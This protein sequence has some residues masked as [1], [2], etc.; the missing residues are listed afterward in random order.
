MKTPKIQMSE[1]LFVGLMLASVGGF[2]ESYSFI[3]RAGVFANCQTGNMVLLAMY[4]TKG[5]WMRVISYLIPI[6][7]FIIG[8]VLTE[9]V[10]LFAL[11]HK[12]HWRQYIILF[13]LFLLAFVGFIPSG[14]YDIIATTVI[15]FSCSMQVESFRKVKGSVYATTMCTGNLRSGTFW[16]FDSVIKKDTDSLMRAGNYFAVI[17]IFMLGAL[18]GGIATDFWGEKSIWLSCLMLLF[19]FFV[20][21]IHPAAEDDG[22]V[23]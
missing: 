4:V 20:L 2:L 19:V 14:R 3:T 11:N 17:L 23:A 18:I 9:L 16:L 15:A 1:S 8:V 6:L 13:E 12:L 5:D 7:S 21:F 22:T 10:R